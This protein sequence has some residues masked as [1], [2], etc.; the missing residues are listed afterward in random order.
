MPIYE[1]NLKN[2]GPFDDIHFE[3]D[4]QIN[5]FVGPNNCGKSTVQM[6]LGDIAVY[7]FST[8]EK[9][10]RKNK[11]EFQVCKGFTYGKR[12]TY[13]G[14]LPIKY[15][16][17]YWDNEEKFRVWTETLKEIGYSCLIPALRWSTDYRAESALSLK[18]EKKEGIR[19]V[20]IIE[21][22]ED[23]REEPKDILKRKALFE[24]EASVVR[25]E[26]LIQRIIDLDYRAY[27][28]KNP[29]IRE[30]VGKIAAIA[31]EITDG[32]P[33][34]FLGVNEDKKGLYPEFM[35][36][37][38]KMPL[39]VLSQGTQSIIQWLGLLLIGYAEYYNFPKNLE[40]KRGVVIIDEIDAHMHPSWQRRILPALSRNFPKLQIFCS[41]HSPFILSGLKAGQAQ[42]LRR[43]DKGKAYVTRNETDIIGWSTDEILR[44]FLDV[45]N[46]TDLQTSENIERL[47]KL[48][49]KK[50]L[51]PKEKKELENLRD[52]VNR[53]LL[54]GPTAGKIERFTE[55]TGKS[56][57]GSRAPTKSKRTKKANRT[58]TNRNRR[59]RVKSEG[60][61]S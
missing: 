36:P 6:A 28:E 35:T 16:S 55:L 50:T 40:K 39:N 9:L 24:P 41:S 12:Q 7:P 21:R 43:N 51:T 60:E 20:V 46:T 34:E 18:K 59:A 23:E 61:T 42:L 2:L 47:Q 31:S 11:A 49:G 53:D 54:A 25:D 38:G 52:K 5:V 56:S 58:P 33:I 10:L 1:L 30:L 19:R 13:N 45:T 26:A 17:K 44:N 15:P 4:P 48:R 32:F 57:A 29:S 14:V 3:F 37:D 27:R 8:P 22:E